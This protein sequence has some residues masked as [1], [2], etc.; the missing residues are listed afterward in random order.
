LPF[1]GLEDA[2]PLVAPAP[3]FVGLVACQSLTRRRYACSAWRESS[4]SASKTRADFLGSRSDALG[5]MGLRV[6]IVGVAFVATIGLYRE[7]F[8]ER[9]R[10]RHDTRRPRDGDR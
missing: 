3:A 6:A 1:E 9:T 8:R 10:R 7:A 5:H 4:R 2:R